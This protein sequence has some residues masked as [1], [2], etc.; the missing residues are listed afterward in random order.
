MHSI[1]TNSI[2]VEDEGTDERLLSRAPSDYIVFDP[3]ET[4]DA[5][6]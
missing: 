6:K 4:N 1:S 5:F 2:N 3:N